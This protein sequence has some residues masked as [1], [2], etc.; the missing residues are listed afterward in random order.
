MTG[1]E[2]RLL[3]QHFDSSGLDS[4]EAFE[5][6]KQAISPVFDLAPVDPQ[7]S[8]S[9]AYDTYHLGDILVGLGRFD[10]T[11]FER[12]RKKAHADGVDHV[13]LQVYARGG[14][15]GWLDGREIT[16]GRGDLVTLDLARETRTR[17][18]ASTNV[19][20][21][22]PRSLIKART[23]PHGHVSIDGVD[24]AGSLMVEHLLSLQRW[25]PTLSRAAGPSVAEATLALC[26]S[27]LAASA[28]A[29]GE[30][31]LTSRD[32]LFQRA[33]RF[34]D[35]RLQSGELDAGALAAALAVSR[36]SLYRLF[37]PYRGVANFVLDRRLS[38]VRKA[39]CDPNDTRRI[40]AI[41]ASCGF[42]DPSHFS[43]IFKRRFGITP[44]EMRRLGAANPSM[45]DSE[46]D[47]RPW[48][49]DIL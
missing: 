12:S 13:L 22:I 31:G 42:V 36:S 27:A 29:D 2:T 40:G 44:I 25:L 7:A 26:N 8:F 35:A 20:V 32:A 46:F 28:L 5:G 15:T 38:H 34:I 39:L 24:A 43:R 48:I 10:P 21:M 18:A 16:V 30:A 3:S 1:D 19:T 33:R 47:L 49:K 14:Y 6:W 4:G 11:I 23:I 41:A 9:A 17:S 45:P 37:E